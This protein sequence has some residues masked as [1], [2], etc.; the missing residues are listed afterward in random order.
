MATSVSL[1]DKALYPMFFRN[2]PSDL[3]EADTLVSMLE[4]YNVTAV[5]IAAISDT[6]GVHASQQ[7]IN[8]LSRARVT[9]TA[10]SFYSAASRN[11][12][13]STSDPQNGPLHSQF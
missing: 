8:N 10:Q 9:V 12:V 7:L 13:L 6:Y 4:H 11:V 3:V 2:A 1:D 5:A